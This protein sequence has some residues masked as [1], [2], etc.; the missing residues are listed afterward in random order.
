M[1]KKPAKNKCQKGCPLSEG[2]SVWS[3]RAEWLRVHFDPLGVAS[4]RMLWVPSHQAEKGSPWVGACSCGTV[5]ASSASMAPRRARPQKKGSWGLLE[6]TAA[7]LPDRKG[8][9]S[10][11][12]SIDNQP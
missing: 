8:I 4:R 3:V 6:H 12:V 11:I 2:S 1:T 9:H 7:G 5:S 10:V